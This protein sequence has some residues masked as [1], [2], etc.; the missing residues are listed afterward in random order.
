MS[1]RSVMDVVRA[2][3]GDPPPDWIETLALECMR[4]SQAK[5][6]KALDV[7]NAAVSQVLRAK[8]AGSTARMEERVR[9]VYL[10]G[11]VDCPALG[12]LPVNECLKHRDRAKAFEMAG[13]TRA[14]MYRACNRC[15]RM[16]RQMEGV[17]NDAEV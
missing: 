2:A 3:W 12:D 16:T 6:A 11:K 4:T 17:E 15:P 1:D 14:L 13:P 8:Y 7:S 10:D 9:G 5:V